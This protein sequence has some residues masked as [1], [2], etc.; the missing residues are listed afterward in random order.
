MLNLKQI[1]PENHPDGLIFLIG[2]KVVCEKSYAT[3]IGMTDKVGNKAKN[4]SEEVN[5]FLGKILTL[6]F[7]TALLS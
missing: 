4:W 2:S 3:V 1:E 7:I 5:I 6:T